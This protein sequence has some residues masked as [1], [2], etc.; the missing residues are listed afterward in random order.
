MSGFTGCDTVQSMPLEQ[1]GPVYAS[2]VKD[3]MDDCLDKFT[4][5]VHKFLCEI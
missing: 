5:D 1:F 4:K 2:Q 3:L